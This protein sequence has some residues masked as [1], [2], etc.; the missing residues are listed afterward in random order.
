MSYTPPPPVNKKPILKCIP[1][2]K[3]TLLKYIILKDF[4]TIQKYISSPLFITYKH[5]NLRQTLVNSQCKPTDEQFIDI[6]LSLPE[7]NTSYTLPA[8]LPIL[9]SRPIQSEPCNHLRCVTCQHFNTNM[10]FTS[11][12][13]RTTYCIRQPFSCNSKNI[14]YLITCTK[15]K[16]Q[17]VGKQRNHSEKESITTAP[18]SET[19]KFDT[20][21]SILTSLITV[22]TTFPYK[23]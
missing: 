11:T 18:A 3:F 12:S 10:F 4:H 21:T 19:T 6:H 15:C 8:K 1:L 22:Y 20:L 13:T 23:P 9:N 16:K 7:I 5:P 2:P 17:Y 14:I